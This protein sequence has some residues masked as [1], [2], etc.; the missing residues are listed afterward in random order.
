M[1]NVYSDQ[2]QNSL[3]VPIRIV[4]FGLVI[5]GKIDY[6]YNILG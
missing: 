4:K 5:C 6:M 1:Y 2:I 3:H